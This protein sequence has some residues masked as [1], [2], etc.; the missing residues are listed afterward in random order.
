MDTGTHFVCGS[1]SVDIMTHAD[2][3]GSGGGVVQCAG[4]MFYEGK[5]GDFLAGRVGTACTSPSVGPYTP[6]DYEVQKV[7]AST[8]SYYILPSPTSAGTA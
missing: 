5:L 7:L 6:R 8:Y 3:R 2:L 1:Q 4:G